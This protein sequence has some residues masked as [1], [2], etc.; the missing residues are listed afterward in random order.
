MSACFSLSVLI[1][2]PRCVCVCVRVFVYIKL[3]NSQTGEILTHFDHF[4]YVRF[5]C[6]GVV[7]CYCC[8]TLHV[9]HWRMAR[10]NY[11][12]LEAPCNCKW[13]IKN[14]M[15]FFFVL[16]QTNNFSCKFE[17]V[18]FPYLRFFGACLFF[19]LVN[20]R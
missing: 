3:K 9:P 6:L 17:P 4:N 18:T 13:A 10:N 5:C 2:I 14:N 7:A 12:L 19:Y 20:I 8:C 16:L 1:S 11:Y 15:H